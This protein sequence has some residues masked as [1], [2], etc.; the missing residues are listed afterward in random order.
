[1]RFRTRFIAYILIIHTSMIVLAFL[2]WKY[3]QV[4]FIITE[5]LVLV[6][7]FLSFALYSSFVK[8]LNI[9]AAATESIKEKDFSIKFVPVGQYEIDQLIDVYNK[10]IDQL[11]V[12]RI[13]TKEKNYFLEQLIQASPTGIILLDLDK[14]IDLVNPAASRLLEITNEG[15]K[16]KFLK[17]FPSSIFQEIDKLPDQ[18]SVIG[19]YEGSKTIRIHKS[20]FIDRG[21]YRYFITLEE[22]TA[23]IIQAEKQAY[24]KVIRMMSHEI[25]NSVGA[26]NSILRSVLSFKTQLDKE[27]AAD[28]EEVLNVSIDRNNKLGKFMSNFADVIRLPDIRKENVDL[29]PVIYSV[30][31]LFSGKMAENFIRFEFEPPS[32]GLVVPVDIYQFEHVLVNIF[33]NAIEAIGTAG[34]ISVNMDPKLKMLQITDT[35]KGIDPEVSKKLF[36][37]FYSTKT[38]GQGIGLT[39]IKEI[40]I[41]HGAAFSLISENGVTKFSIKFG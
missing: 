33:K 31:K 14:S 12:E 22:I 15:A 3:D 16:G 41:K 1:M 13:I 27:S 37:P 21:I 20:H 2:L 39:L 28:F 9:L 23:E 32:A 26:V 25:N 30:A 29:V 36:T 11:R 7:L 40:L 38:E 10:M 6:S 35:G 19:K 8:P 4:L 18:E 34:T 24:G 17:D 5:A